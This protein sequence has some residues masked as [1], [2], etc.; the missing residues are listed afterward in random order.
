MAFT[1]TA[2]TFVQVRNRSIRVNGDGL[3]RDRKT[4]N[5]TRERKQRKR[6]TKCRRN[7]E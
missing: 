1:V 3:Y 5:G 2:T 7:E 4:R 6:E